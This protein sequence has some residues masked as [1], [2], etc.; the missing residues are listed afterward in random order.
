[1]IFYP[2]GAKLQITKLPHLSGNH[3][4]KQIFQSN[5]VTYSASKYPSNFQS[6]RL[7]IEM[8]VEKFLNFDTITHKT[9]L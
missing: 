2:R 5:I 1:M 3:R 9:L 8:K 6:R 7:E 4:Q